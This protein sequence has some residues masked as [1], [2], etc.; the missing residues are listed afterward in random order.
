MRAKSLHEEEPG[1][2]S[3]HTANAYSVSWPLCPLAI[4]CA[5]AWVPTARSHA[6]VHVFQGCSVAMLSSLRQPLL[7]LW[8]AL[9]SNALVHLFCAC[10]V[11]L[12][13][14]LLRPLLCQSLSDPDLRRF[15]WYSGVALCD[16]IN[17]ATLASHCRTF[18]VAISRLCGA[19][20]CSVAGDSKGGS[21]S[22]QIAFATWRLPHSLFNRASALLL[23]C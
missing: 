5:Y 13:S 19:Y 3:T 8:S 15:S 7:C 6:L 10:S 23:F 17:S 14:P 22:C 12:L 21:P 2:A 20:R 4:P 18:A 11:A 9:C 1:V 16:W